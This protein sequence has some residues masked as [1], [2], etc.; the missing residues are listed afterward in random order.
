MSHDDATAA[1]TL[2]A[3]NEPTAAAYARTG[4]ARSASWP[5]ATEPTRLASMNALNAQPYR[6]SPP[7]SRATAGITVPTPSD[8]NATIVTLISTPMLIAR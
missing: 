5:A 2:P 7:R 8:W 4:P 1:S 6:S 3:A